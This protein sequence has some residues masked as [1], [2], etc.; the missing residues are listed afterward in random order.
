[1]SADRSSADGRT[2]TS[3]PS[4]AWMRHS[5]GK[6]PSKQIA[7]PIRPRSV[8]TTQT[9]SPGVTQPPRVTISVQNGCVL[10]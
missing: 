1:M 2:I 10:R 4:T 8:S 6:S 3:A 9:S 5:S 7:M